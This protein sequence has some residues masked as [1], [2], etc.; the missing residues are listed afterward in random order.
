MSEYRPRLVR[1]PDRPDTV[2]RGPSRSPRPCE[3]ACSL[4]G[5]RGVLVKVQSAGVLGIEAYAV[6][7]QVDVAYGL[8]QYAVVGLAAGA[9]KEGGVR[10]PAALKHSGFRLPPSRVTINLAPA[11]VRK[12]GA[13][14]DLPIA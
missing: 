7:A 6:E 9:V 13:A 12:D 11:D 2:E 10:V 8:P 1:K 14:F 4:L 3:Q 5:G